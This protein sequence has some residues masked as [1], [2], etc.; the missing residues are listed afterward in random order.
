MRP[1]LAR[2]ARIVGVTD[3]RTT[4]RPGR[5]SQQIFGSNYVMLPAVL[6]SQ[7]ASLS[8]TCP[9]PQQTWIRTKLQHSLHRKLGCKLLHTPLKLGMEYGADSSKTL[10]KQDSIVCYFRNP[11][12]YPNEMPV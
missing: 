12:K 10:R 11:P 3:L 1:S 8:A 5:A 6:H 2:L 7:A 9:L 4:P